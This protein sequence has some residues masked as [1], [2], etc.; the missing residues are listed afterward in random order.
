M[1]QKTGHADVVWTDTRGIAQRYGKSD[2]TISRWREM[3]MPF[4]KP[5]GS[6]PGHVL[7]HVPSCD[8]WLL[9]QCDGEVQ[10]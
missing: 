5:S 2:K 1:I 3:G 8:E 9:S 7:Y 6:R 4:S 10:K